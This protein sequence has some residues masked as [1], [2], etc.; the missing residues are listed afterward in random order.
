MEKEYEVTRHRFGHDPAL[1]EMVREQ[2]GSGAM[3]IQ[4]I[5]DACT[6]AGFDGRAVATEIATLLMDG[7]LR[8]SVPTSRLSGATVI[9]PVCRH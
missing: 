6:I 7:A 8:P 4:D 3:S 2:A 9:E 1:E 5:V